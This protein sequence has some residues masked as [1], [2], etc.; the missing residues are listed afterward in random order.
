[1]ALLGVAVND[2][3]GN[4]IELVAEIHSHRAD[5]R[6]VAEAG[7]GVIAQVVEIEVPRVVPDVAGIAENNSTQISPD[8]D[9]ELGGALEHRVAADR[10]TIEQRRH[11]EAAPAAEALRAAQPVATVER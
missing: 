6:E 1:M 7:S 8:R 2:Q 4:R 9:A 3:S 5:R 11:L 10:I